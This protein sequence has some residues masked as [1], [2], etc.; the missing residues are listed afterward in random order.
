[1]AGCGKSGPPMPIGPEKPGNGTVP[2]TGEPNKRIEFN[3]D[4]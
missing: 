4:T 3:D 2:G 1:M